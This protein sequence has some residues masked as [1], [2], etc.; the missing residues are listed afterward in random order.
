M[1]SDWKEI[2]KLTAARTGKSEQRYKEVGNFVFAK[3]YETLRRPKTLITKLKGI[4]TWYL[5]RKRM[6]IVVDVFPP[7]FDKKPEDFPTK[8]DLF[9]YE[10]RVEIYRLFQ[11]RLEEYKKYI[12]LR[13]EIRKKRYETQKL[14]EP[15]KGEDED[16]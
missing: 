1:Q 10:N 8:L 9:A 14:L 2:Y 16:D 11:E 13:D 6:R 5:R 4:G 12:E 7:D 3:L 15:L